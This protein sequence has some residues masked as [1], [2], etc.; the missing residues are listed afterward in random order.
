MEAVHSLVRALG[1]AVSGRIRFRSEYTG[2]VLT[3]DDR[4]SFT[5]FRHMRVRTPEAPN[6][7]LL[8]VRFRFARLSHAA[9]KRASRI[10]IPLIA[11]F[12]GFRQKLW[13]IDEKSGYWQGLY[14]WRDRESLKNYLGSFVLGL[15]NRR[16]EQD[17]VSYEILPD[18]PLA[19]YLPSRLKEKSLPRIGSSKAES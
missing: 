5:I 1:L 3:A 6:P 14:E 12:P 2:R 15:M 13:M 11:G 10:P 19:E 7:A 18:T 16:A 17:S 8:V 9:N 4:I